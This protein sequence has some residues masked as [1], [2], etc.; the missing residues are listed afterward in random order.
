[1][2]FS[3]ENLDDAELVETLRQLA[4]EWKR[5]FRRRLGMTPELA[6]FYACQKL[7]LTRMPPENRG[8][9]AIDQ[10]GRRYQIKG[11]AP[12]RGDTVNPNGTVGRFVN[13]D[14]DY[15]L[16]VILGGDLRCREIWRATVENLEVEQAKVR[17]ERVGIRVSTF[18]EL[19]ERFDC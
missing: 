15:A 5:R 9:D 2:N 14:F 11:R 19:G 16:L 10:S 4:Q 17:N 12:D 1:M 18:Q 8:F 13:F 7:D 3:F 6:E